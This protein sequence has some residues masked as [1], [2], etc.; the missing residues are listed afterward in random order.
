MMWMYHSLFN[1]SPVKGHLGYLQFLPIKETQTGL[2]KNM[3]IEMLIAMSYYKVFIGL[4]RVKLR[5]KTYVKTYDNLA[6]RSL[7]P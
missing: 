4:E 2:L 1:H 3:I 5:T 6:Q 7:I